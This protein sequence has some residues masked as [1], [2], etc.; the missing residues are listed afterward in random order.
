MSWLRTWW[1]QP[2]HFDW[3]SGYLQTRQLSTVARRVLALFAGSLAFVPIDVL[4]GPAPFDRRLVLGPAVLAAAAGLGMA[5]LWLTRWPTRRQSLA[6]GVIGCVTIASGCLWQSH[7]VVGL[8]SCTALAV[9]GGYVAFFH[10]APYMMLNFALAS[11]VGA[12]EAVRVA[13][14]GELMLAVS[15]CF[16]VLELNVIVPLTI[17]IMVRSLQGDLLR[18][19]SDP[20]T[21]LLNRRAFTRAVIGQMLTAADSDVIMLA[22]VDLDRF[23]DLNDRLGHADGDAA[24]VAVG[25]ALR[26]VS[27]DT[28]LIGRIGGEEFL[29]ADMLGSRTPTQ[30]GQY[31]CSAV[32]EIPFPCTAS[33]GVVTRALRGVDSAAVESMLRQLAADADRAMYTAKRRGGNQTYHPCS[34]AITAKFDETSHQAC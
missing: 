33:V 29:I 21:G 2:D 11:G 26:A 23:K 12:V 8:M 7:A 13:S 14:A 17:Q 9:S 1:R 30:W 25:N 20:L 3:I 19:D 18:S 28:A 15:G 16:L 24:L 27:G 34:V 5:A 10:T 31:I 6:Y 22:M 32:A 4:W